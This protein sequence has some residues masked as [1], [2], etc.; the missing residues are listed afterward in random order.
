M[1]IILTYQ[2]TQLTSFEW[3]GI[4]Y[5]SISLS[6]NVIL[7]LMIVVRLILHAR[8][9]RAVMGETGSGGLCKAIVTMFIESFAI[10]AVTS[11][12]VLGVIGGGNGSLPFFTSILP[13]TQVRAFS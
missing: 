12:L 4:P 10:N 8:G 2:S 3:A 13:E 11:V 9:V 6:L 7:T 5:F 1:G